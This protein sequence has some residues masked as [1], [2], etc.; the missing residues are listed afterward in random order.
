MCDTRTEV[1]VAHYR[2]VDHGE[3]MLTH[4]GAKKRAE[5]LRLYLYLEDYGA[6][7]TLFADY[8]DGRSR[9]EHSTRESP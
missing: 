3:G 1:P 5:A 6:A 8:S 4:F 7:V 2:V 9:V